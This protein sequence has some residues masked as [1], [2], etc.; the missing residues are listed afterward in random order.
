MKFLFYPNPQFLLSKAIH[1]S[2]SVSGFPK[3]FKTY[4]PAPPGFALGMTKNKER[5]FKM[6]RC[7][8][9]SRLKVR[10]VYSKHEI[11]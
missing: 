2:A 5:K 8:L 1:S 10:D 3:K 6:S 9:I 11:K 7:Y 4:T